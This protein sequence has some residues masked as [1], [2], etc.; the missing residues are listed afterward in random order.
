MKTAMHIKKTLTM[1][2]T[3]NAVEQFFY[4]QAGYSYDPAKETEEEGKCRGAIL[5]A[6]AERWANET[7]YSFEWMID[8]GASSADWIDDREDG[9]KYCDP[10]RVWACV[11]CDEGGEAVQSLWS[12]DFGRDGEPWGNPYRR[13][14]EAELALEEWGM[15]AKG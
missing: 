1:E 15:I 9:G 8:E 12:I 11:M 7:G 2:A 13:V 10:W 6:S 4:D 3:M 5:L 14:V